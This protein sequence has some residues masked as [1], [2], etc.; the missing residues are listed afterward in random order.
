MMK[1]PILWFILVGAILFVAD[2]FLT[3]ER[4]LLVIDDGVR[5]RLSSLWQAQMGSPATEEQVS[6]IV[7][8][9]I[10]E[11]VMLRE[12]LRLN[13]DRDDT[14]IRRRL[15]QKLEFLAE[16]VTGELPG[17]DALESFYQNNIADYSEPRR[18]S[19]SQIY[20]S[21]EVRAAE[22]KDALAKQDDWKSLGDVT[23]LSSQ[24]IARSKREIG[25]ILGMGFANEVDSFVLNQWAGPFK[26]SFGYH[27]VRLER[28]D[29]PAAVPMASIE[30]KVLADYQ[31]D[32]KKQK[33]K[34]YYQSLLEKTE[35]EYR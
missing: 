16:D 14:I 32:Q 2:G 26:S 28:V 22:L 30:M 12:A 31:A 34:T 19:F 27:Y 33:L 9:W 15:V 4:E 29:E 20:F 3:T 8:A 11:E 18:Y 13:L 21:E 35:L 24:Y 7:D 1:E 17:N 6:S 10:R 23:M 25:I 5:A